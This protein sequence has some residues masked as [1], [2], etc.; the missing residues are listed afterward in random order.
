MAESAE[1]PRRLAAVVLSHPHPDHF[2]GLVS[3]LGGVA[4]AGEGQCI[5]AQTGKDRLQLLMEV[6]EVG[7]GLLRGIDGH[8]ILQRGAVRAQ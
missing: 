5:Y 2:T 8:Q 3:G 7:G 1:A 6:M 4:V